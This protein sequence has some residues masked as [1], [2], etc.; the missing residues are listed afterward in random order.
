MVKQLRDFAH[1]Q[2]EILAGRLRE[3]NV[4][5]GWA[6]A[7]AGLGRKAIHN[8]IDRGRLDAVRIGGADEGHAV[9]LLSQSQVENLWTKSPK[10]A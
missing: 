1:Y 10:V 7:Y 8:S 9:V 3:F 6:A 4:S 2:R 5:P